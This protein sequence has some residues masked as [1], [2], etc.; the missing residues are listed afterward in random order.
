MNKRRAYI[1]DTT[2]EDEPEIN[3]RSSVNQKIKRRKKLSRK[4]PPTINRADEVDMCNT[5]APKVSAKRRLNFDIEQEAKSF[6]DNEAGCS[7]KV[8]QIVN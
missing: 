2:S 7:D 8:S 1:L 5:I 4:G 3:L 6:L